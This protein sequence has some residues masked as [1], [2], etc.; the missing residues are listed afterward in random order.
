MQ[1]NK[2]SI[3]C[4]VSSPEAATRS[5]VEEN[6]QIEYLSFIDIKPVLHTELREQIKGLSP[7]NLIAVFTSSNAVKAVIKILEN[8]KTSWKIYCTSGVTSKETR[9]YFGEESIV[10][11]DHNALA[12]AQKIM[13]DGVREVVFFCGD[14]RRDELP[15]WLAQHGVKVNEIL[16]YRTELTPRKISK[17]YNGILFFSPSA[18]ESFFS[19]NEP[20]KETVFFSIGDT[21]ADTIKKYSPNKII[22]SEIPDKELLIRVASEYFQTNPVNI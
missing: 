7:Q 6:I 1:K 14:Q 17:K 20:D 19:V 13:H 5:L 11:T 22:V 12:L 18:A 3:L 10:G 9:A 2:A 8:Q 15:A 4:T 16:V 21:T